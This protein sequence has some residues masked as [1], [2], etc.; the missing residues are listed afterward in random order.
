MV[1]EFLF[2]FLKGPWEDLGPGVV[3]SRQLGPAA[4]RGELGWPGFSPCW[5]SRG[6]PCVQGFGTLENPDCSYFQ[7]ASILAEK[8]GLR[9]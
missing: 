7:G 4:I 6:P 2:W 3:F 8:V 9:Q 5:G 1:R